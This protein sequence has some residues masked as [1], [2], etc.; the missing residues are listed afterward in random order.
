MTEPG[1]GS[2]DTEWRFQRTGTFLDV[3]SDPG[4][5]SWADQL[6]DRAATDPG[7]QSAPRQDA[8]WG[9]RGGGWQDQ[10]VRVLEQRVASWQLGARSD[11]VRSLRDLLTPL[12]PDV[13]VLGP[14]RSHSAPPTPMERSSESARRSSS[15]KTSSPAAAPAIPPTSKSPPAAADG[16]ETPPPM[17]QLVGMRRRGPWQQRG[18]DVSESTSPDGD[19]VAAAQPPPSPPRSPR[20]PW[21]LLC[22]AASSSC[23]GLLSDSGASRPSAPAAGSGAPGARACSGEVPASGSQARGASASADARCVLARPGGLPSVGSHGHPE[24]CNR[25]CWYWATAGGCR[26]HQECEFCHLPHPKRGS[27]RPERWCRDTLQQMS[28]DARMALARAVVVERALALGLGTP[29]VQAVDTWFGQ[30]ERPDPDEDLER[31]QGH[32][33]WGE[34]EATLRGQSI[35]WLLTMAQGGQLHGQEADRR[36]CELVDVLRSLL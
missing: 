24:L 25:P 33:Q 34:V 10:Y 13:F 27:V 9:R 18:G 28:S 15:S 36:A 32:Q 26:N 7:P 4:S 2:T 23:P 31:G 3:R 30:L 35:R 8:N 22:G 16:S 29:G 1:T 12:I 20:Q 6:E 19:L 14:R 21:R 11:R 5:D 17:Q